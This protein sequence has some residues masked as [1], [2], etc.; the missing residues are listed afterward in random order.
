MTQFG[1]SN[2]EAIL[3]VSYSAA[4]GIIAAGTDKG[5]VAMWKFMPNVSKFGEPEASWQLLHAKALQPSPIKQLKVL[6]SSFSLF[7]IFFYFFVVVKVW[8]KFKFDR[9]EFSQRRFHFKRA[10]NELRLSRWC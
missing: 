10:E 2:T 8:H 6:Y 5:N 3:T 9:R 7:T 1:F 4:K